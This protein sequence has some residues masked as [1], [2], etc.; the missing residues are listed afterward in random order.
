MFDLF[1]SREFR[2]ILSNV[3]EIKI[4]AVAN[5]VRVYADFCGCKGKMIV[6]AGKIRRMNLTKRK[7]TTALTINRYKSLI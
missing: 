4:T 1:L 6:P 7:I 5:F 2:G 3:D